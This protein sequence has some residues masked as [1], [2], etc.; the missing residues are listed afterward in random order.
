M[1]DTKVRVGEYEVRLVVPSSYT[2]RAEVDEAAL[3]S[4]R[5]GAAAALGVCWVAS[6]S[7]GRPRVQFGACG[8]NPTVYGGA[9]LDELV[10]RGVPPEDVVA[11]GL[12]ALALIR[13]SMPSQSE[14]EEEAGNSEP[15]PGIDSS[16]MSSSSGD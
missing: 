9:V 12:V 1:S 16:S 13:E 11:A 14:V 4:Y 5:R 10:E 8:H 15:G 7:K 6:G 3:F 2:V